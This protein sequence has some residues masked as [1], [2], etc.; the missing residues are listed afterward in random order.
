MRVAIIGSG[1]AG[2]ATA[3]L[4]YRNHEISLFESDSR[5]G[6]HVH[7]VK[8]NGKHDTVDVD[9]GFI[10]Y[11]ERNYPNFVKLIQE[12][13]IETQPSSMS[14]SVRITNPDLEYN[15]STLR[16]LFV[17]KRNLFRPWF[18]KMVR[19]ILRFNRTAPDAISGHPKD[20]T[21]R[22][23]LDDHEFTGAFVEYYLVPMGAAIWSTPVN[24]VLDMPA[25]FFIRFF[26]NHG[27]LT[28][29]DRPEWRV[30]KGGSHRYVKKIIKP[31]AERIRLNHTVQQVERFPDHVTVDGEQFDEVV[32]ACHSNQA[33][34]MLKDPSAAE[35]SILGAIPYQT[36]EVVLH[37]DTRLL[38]RRP[39]AWAAWNYRASGSSEKS[40][41]VALT[42]NMNILQSLEG[43][44]VFCV[45]LNDAAS[46]KDEEVLGRFEYHH[47]LFTLNGITAQQRHGEISGVART[48]YCGAYWGYGF[49]ED[50]L[51]SALAVAR[52]F[53][54]AV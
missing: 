18:Y 53:G 1:I 30:I 31:F 42:Y 4:L 49:H 24:Q 16:Q 27:M 12:L 20:W 39:K 36:N 15:G 47:P 45:T 19:D 51:N 13:D 38:P 23:F 41:G 50:G 25:H 44:D 46:V 17:D 6:G 7:T 52:A 14:F 28:V 8:V 22:E 9:T 37:T 21:L 35:R 32:L 29:D 40:A 33:L 34:S 10:V 54:V 2:L 43:P 3:H 26:E 48:H 11:N 5:I